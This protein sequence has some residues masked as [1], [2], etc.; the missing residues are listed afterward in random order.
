MSVAQ[1]LV[2]SVVFPCITKYHKL[3]NLIHFSLDQSLGGL[4]WVP[5]LGSSKVDDIE[6]STRLGSNPRPP[7]KTRC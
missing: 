3:S 6:V 1:A 5:C 7:E 2:H 4:R